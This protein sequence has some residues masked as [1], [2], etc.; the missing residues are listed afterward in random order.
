MTHTSEKHFTDEE[1]EL[2][3]R[4][5]ADGMYMKA[6]NGSPT[7]L[8]ERQWVQVRTRA[9][10]NWFGD[11]E[12]APEAASRIVDENG[13]PLVVHHGTPLRR[14]Q[15]TPERGWQRDGITYI[16]QKAPFHTFKG[17][18]YSGLIFTSVDAEKARGI[19]ET[20]AMSIPDDKYGNEQWTEE[21]YVY[22]LYVNSRNPFDPKDG[23]AVKKI[24]Q[25]L[26]SEIPSPV[27]LWRKRR[28][29]IPGVKRWSW[30]QD[31]RN[32]LDADGKPRSFCPKSRRRATTGLSVTTR[33]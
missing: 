6:P 5:K 11:W 19:A 4:G 18:E 14:D 33:E 25:S 24:L 29:G 32:C 9:F 27:F 31:K 3:T 22:D 17:G 13:E 16:P 20:R 10:K 7:S 28:Y 30:H 2:V 26:G 15:I 8:D 1:L 23:Q 12:N 21:G